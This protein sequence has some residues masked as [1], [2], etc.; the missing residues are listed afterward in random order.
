MGICAPVAFLLFITL[1][2]T[3]NAMDLSGTWYAKTP[4]E[5]AIT[6]TKTAS[7]YR[8]TYYSMGKDRGGNPVSRISSNKADVTF[9]LDHK[10]GT[11]SGHISPDG[12]SFSG[13]WQGAGAQ[14]VSPKQAVTF[15]RMGAGW[16]VDSSPHKTRFVSVGKGVKLEVLDWGGNG[17]PLVLLTGWGNTAHAFDTLAPKLT[18][19]HHVYAI[20]RRGFGISSAPP[21]T[22]E[23]FDP[24]RLADDDLAV[25]AALKLDRPILAGHSVAGQELSSIGT[26]HPEK[27]SGLI[28]LE[29]E[30]YSF[31]DSK[32]GF[33]WQVEA[34]N[35]RRELEDLPKGYL[36]SRKAIKQVLADIPLLQKSLERDLA[37][38]EGY[39]DRDPALPYKYQEQVGDVM[40]TTRRK[41]TGIK[42]PFLAIFAEP[43]KC[44]PSC[45][46][47]NQKAWAD[48]VK[49]Q[50]DAVA[51]DYPNAR[52]VRLPNATHYV[53]ESNEADVLREMNAFMDA[54]P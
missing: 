33:M 4:S 18:D 1:C 7:G 17:R 42:A 8:G 54:I 29:A 53:F 2:A 48:E 38:S 11:F 6:I 40:A 41:Y 32:G 25:I 14:S 12:K 35:L 28:Y 45:D 30:Y 19:K 24:D 10:F 23:N 44:D 20:T 16:S 52:I 9:S 21:P 36:D 37:V 51:A 46:V 49:A 15:E 43:Y 34:D 26:R 50:A 39:P 3:A 31:Y 27:I 22:R 13:F 47:P 5:R